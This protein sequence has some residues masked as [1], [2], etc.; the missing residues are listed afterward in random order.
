[1][2]EDEAKT[3]VCP[4]RCGWDI[5]DYQNSEILAYCMGSQCMKWKWDRTRAE[6]AKLNAQSNCNAVASGHCGMMKS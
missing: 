1:M 2:T 4:D 3:K 6:A 5:T